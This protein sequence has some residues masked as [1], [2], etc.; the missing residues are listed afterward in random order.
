MKDFGQLKAAAL[1]NVA[2]PDTLNN[3]RD[4]FPP[5]T[6]TITLE[7]MGPAGRCPPDI[8]PAT[9][10]RFEVRAASPADSGASQTSRLTYNYGI[11]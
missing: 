4:N 6:A 8:I 11:V 9:I 2:S 10:R 5:G 7:I 1:V 3:P